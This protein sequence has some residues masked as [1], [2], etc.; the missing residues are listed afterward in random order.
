MS[1]LDIVTALV[2]RFEGCRLVG[3]LDQAGVPTWGYGHTGVGQSG[4]PRVGQAIT[5]ETADCLLIVDIHTADQRLSSACPAVVKLN[6]NQRAALIDFVFNLGCDPAWT[7]WAD[8][9]DG[10]LAQV[11]TQ[12]ARFCHA[13]IDGKMVVDDGLK[14]RRDAEIALWNTPV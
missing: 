9:N 6:A 3:Y 7:I 8:I 11:P 2:K 13:E 1:Y 5:Q 14:N 4:R 12:I 10:D